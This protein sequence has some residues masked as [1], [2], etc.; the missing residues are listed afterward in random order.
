MG[1][2]KGEMTRKAILARALALASE[3]G[4]EGLTI[5]RLASDLSLSKSGLFAHFQ[6]K[7]ELQRQVLDFAAT[8]FVENVIRPAFGADPGEPR[9]RALFESW[10]DWPR[11]DPLPGGCFFV[12]A[13]TELDDRP[14][15]LRDRLVELQR[16]WLNVLADSA[17]GAA[18]EGHF[19]PDVDPEQFA[20]DVHGIMLAYHHASRLLKD[21]KAKARVRAAFDALVQAARPFEPSAPGVPAPGT[22]AGRSAGAEGASLPAADLWGRG[23]RSPHPDPDQ[24]PAR[25]GVS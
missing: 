14:G 3:V 2:N 24:P 7:E 21:P 18:A 17:R 6:S 19:R 12:S 16:S 5:G 25:T 8:R 22:T 13:A 23:S 10:L 15:P 4:L 11:T 1:V 9:V 20:Y